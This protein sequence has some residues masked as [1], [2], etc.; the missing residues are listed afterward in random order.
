VTDE[1][2]KPGCP[3]KNSFPGFADHRDESPTSS[4][5]EFQTIVAANNYWRA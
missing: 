2:A 5:M 4:P 1:T 3:M